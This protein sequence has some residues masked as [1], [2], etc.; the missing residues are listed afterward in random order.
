MKKYIK[1]N[2]RIIPNNSN[3]FKEKLKTELLDAALSYDLLWKYPD[4]IEEFGPT[5][6]CPKGHTFVDVFDYEY[7]DDYDDS[8]HHGLQIKFRSEMSYEEMQI[9]IDNV[10]NPIIQKYDEDAY[11]DFYTSTVLEAYIYFD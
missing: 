1:S 8:I 4:L 7:Y 5:P 3:E 9:L 11:F 6:L 10:L 2:S